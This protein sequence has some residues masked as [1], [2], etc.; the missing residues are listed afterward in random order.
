MRLA[1]DCGNVS[2]LFPKGVT[3]LHELPFTVHAAINRALHFLSFEKLDADERPPKKIWL[4]DEAM[5]RWWAD[6]KQAREDKMKGGDSTMSM[7]QNALLE[8]VFPGMRFP[9]G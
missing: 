5:E 4:D 6:V 1:R 2:S 7:P 3:T 8:K 9:R